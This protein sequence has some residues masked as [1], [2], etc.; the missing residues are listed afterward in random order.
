ME[1][2]K[3]TLVITAFFTLSACTKEEHEITESAAPNTVSTSTLNEDPVQDGDVKRSYFSEWEKLINWNRRDSSVYYVYSMARPTPQITED[4]LNTGVVLVYAKD[5]RSDE[6]VL[7]PT[8]TKLSFQLEGGMEYVN[9]WYQTNQMEKVT[10][11][12]RSNKFHYSNQPIPEPDGYTRFRFFVIPQ[13]ELER[14]G[15]SR[16][17]IQEISYDKLVALLHT[18]P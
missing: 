3:S 9:E 6:G 4:I 17:S 2:W 14:M 13:T 18:S 15:Y 5:Y 10:V 7:Q 12:F 16:S 8:P 11:K 1:S